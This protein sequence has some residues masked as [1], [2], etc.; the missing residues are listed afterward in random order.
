MVT[1]FTDLRAWQAARQFR[2]RV[3]VLVDRPSFRNRNL[4]KQLQRAADSIPANI[5]EGFGRLAVND[6]LH[7]FRM[8]L[9]SSY[10]TQSHLL[11]AYDDGLVSSAEMN[12]CQLAAD[13]TDRLLLAFM[14][15]LGPPTTSARRT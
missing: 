4:A 14:K 13:L 11:L 8:A 2:K 15:S 7:F 3:M 1:R 10:E 12:E 6:R 5:A 9:G